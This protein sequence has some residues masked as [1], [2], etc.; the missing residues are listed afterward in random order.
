MFVYPCLFST[1]H[2]VSAMNMSSM[3]EGKVKSS[4]QLDKILGL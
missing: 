3:N 1:Y 2:I 4:L